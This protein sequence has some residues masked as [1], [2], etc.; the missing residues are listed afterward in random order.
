VIV[1]ER[2]TITEHYLHVEHV[3]RDAIDDENALERVA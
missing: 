2:I 1:I 3:P